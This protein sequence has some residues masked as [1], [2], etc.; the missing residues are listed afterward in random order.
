M[1]FS[2]GGDLQVQS[3]RGDVEISSGGGSVT[4]QDVRGEV[5]CELGGGNIEIRDVIGPAEASTGGGNV[6]IDRAQGP[7]FANTQGGLLEVRNAAGPVVA[8]N[9]EGILRV[10]SSRNVKAYAPTGPMQLLDVEGSLALS[11]ATGNIYAELSPNGISS[12]SR[13]TSE[14]GDITIVLPQRLKL[15]VEAE[16]RCSCAYSVVSDFSASKRADSNTGSAGANSR[17]RINGGGP[18]LSV[19]TSSGRIFVK[20]SKVE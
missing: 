5:R 4:I 18:T 15:A 19:V 20:K 8:R 9:R 14:G 10:F 6:V 12:D 16:S 1:V 17:M 7:V 2:G 13:I 3:V 11:T